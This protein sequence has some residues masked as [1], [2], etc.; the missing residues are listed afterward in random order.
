MSPSHN[1]NFM[2]AHGKYV[3]RGDQAGYAVVKFDE[4]TYLRA[5]WS[6][7]DGNRLAHL[8]LLKI[9]NGSPTV[10]LNFVAKPVSKLQGETIYWCN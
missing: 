3:V 7:E 10:K 6:M 4:T 8:Q 5:T 2:P 1:L 9:E